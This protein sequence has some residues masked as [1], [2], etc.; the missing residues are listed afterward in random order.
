M[1]TILNKTGLV[2]ILAIALNAC[3]DDFLNKQPTDRLSA[4]VFYTSKADLDK[5]LTSCYALIQNQSF[6]WSVPIFECISDNGYGTTGIWNTENIARGPVTP[7][8]GSIGDIYSTSYSR[9]ARYNIFLKNLADYSGS[10]IGSDE[11]ARYEAEARLLRGM[12]YFELY[13]FYGAVPLIVEPLTYETQNQPKAEENAIW[14]QVMEDVDYAIARLPA[15][16]FAQNNGHF[17]KTAAQVVKARAL[18]YTAYNEDKTAKPDVMNQVRQL[19]GEIISTGFYRIESSYRGLFCDDLGEQDGNP[20][21]IFTVNY[22]GPLNP[23]YAAYNEGPYIG[24]C[25]PIDRGGRCLPLPNF[26]REY[27]FIDGTSFSENNPLYDPADIYKNRDPRMKQTVFTEIVT[28]ENGFSNSAGPAITG[29]SFWKIVTGTNALDMYTPN[30]N[31]DWPLMRYAEVLLM[32]AEAVNEL[33]GPTEEVY[34]AINSI[35]ARTG[36]DMPPLAS[37]LTKDQMRQTI[38]KERRIEL[39]FEGFRYDDV[40]RWKIAEERLNMEASEGVVNRTFEKRNYHW[41]LPQAEVD[42][43]NGILLQNPDYI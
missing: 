16:A 43:S 14:N 24:Y 42:K 30:L 4:E 7:T 41:P 35:R 13:K 32:H 12:A 39:A 23:A 11:R 29:F 27:E 8:T 9:I 40:K 6:T 15:V 5:A 25:L 2:F 1:K 17:V 3:S 19:T 26:V 37:G 10:D 28:F 38:R 36:V 33:D 18:I 34:N 31:S 21:F 22:Q 20:E